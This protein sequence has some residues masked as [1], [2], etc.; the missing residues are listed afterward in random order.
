MIGVQGLILH[1]LC[2]QTSLGWVQVLLRNYRMLQIMKRAKVVSGERCMGMGR[3]AFR[4]LN[5]ISLI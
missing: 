4:L 1:F 3:F 2:I 5:S